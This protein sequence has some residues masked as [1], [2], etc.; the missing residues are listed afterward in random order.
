M[1]NILN[2][3]FLVTISAMTSCNWVKDKTKTTVNRAGE[4]VAKTG[5]EFGN[6]V[7]KGVKK[8]FQNNIQLSEELKNKGL[9]FGEVSIN[10]TDTTSDNVLTTYIIFKND[11][12]K[13]VTIKLF[14]EN[15]KEYGR[16]TQEIKGKKDQAK[17]FDFTFDKRVNIG[18]KGNITFE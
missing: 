4:I 14:D 9:E 12:D 1:K 16:L 18:V 6:G 8:T 3:I 10:S 15:G 5:S 2:I 11:F 17:Y 13:M 7:Y